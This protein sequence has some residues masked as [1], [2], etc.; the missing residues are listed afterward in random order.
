MAAPLAQPPGTKPRGPADR[1]RRVATAHRSGLNSHMSTLVA[2][3]PTQAPPQRRRSHRA[4]G[5]G[6]GR[7]ADRPN[8]VL[9]DDG[10]DRDADFQAAMA[11]QEWEAAVGR[12]GRRVASALCRRGGSHYAYL[13]LP[14][15]TYMVQLVEVEGSARSPSKRSGSGA[16]RSLNHLLNFTFA[17][18]PRPAPAPMPRRRVAYQPYSKE[19]YVNAKYAGLRT[20]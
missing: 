16:V 2:P 4:R 5:R 9:D 18:R 14:F 12:R 11:A 20:A 8:L 10:D 17:E 6:T 13:P 19:R 15:L 3:G 7:A 1:R